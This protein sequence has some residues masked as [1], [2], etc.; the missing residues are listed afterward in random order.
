MQTPP[1]AHVYRQAVAA[2]VDPEAPFAG[3]TSLGPMR[4]EH[5]GSGASKWL[6]I[7]LGGLSVLGAAG[8]VL[9]AGIGVLE[10]LSRPRG[11]DIG[12]ALIGP[13]VGLVIC[14]GLGALFFW[15]AW[16][17]W[18][19]AAALF[20]EGFA[21]Y[22]RKGLR[23][24]PWDDIDLVYQSIIKRYVNGVYAGTMHTYTVML[25][26][27]ARLVL[28]DRLRDVEAIGGAVVKTSAVR[29]LPRYAAAV[30][31]GQRVSFGPL[32]LDLNGLYS[33]SKSLA[34]GE[35]KAVKLDRGILSVAKEGKWLNWTSATVPQIPNFYVLMTL[36]SRFTQVE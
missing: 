11:G 14:L 5:K 18:R 9:V 26:D 4:S 1:H 29:L 8:C 32:A 16:R 33:G 7:V 35:I 2:Y 22:D 30:Q 15:I 12:D 27:G 24:V 34:W 31:A 25:R 23:V 3:V 6:G 36:L 19:L 13:L 20:E 17:N 28:D 10:Q 21:Y